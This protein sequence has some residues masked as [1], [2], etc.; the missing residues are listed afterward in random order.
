MESRKLIR[1]L[2]TAAT[3]A[4]LTAPTAGAVPIVGGGGLTPNAWALAEYI[5]ANYPGVLSIG[6]VRQDPYPDHPS[7]RAIDIMVG[8]NAAL[9]NQIAADIQSQAGRFGVSYIMWQTDPAHHDHVH[10]SVL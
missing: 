9:G 7:G 6:G 5:Q 10:V 2:A 4:L 1:R 3:A 8:T